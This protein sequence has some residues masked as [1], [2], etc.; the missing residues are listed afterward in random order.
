MTQLS[1]CRV[2]PYPLK[3][4]LYI[5]LPSPPLTLP[6]RLVSLEGTTVQA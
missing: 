4:Q 6:C 2:L 3:A 5:P 1:M